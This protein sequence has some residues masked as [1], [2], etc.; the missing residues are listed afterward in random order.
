MNS[1]LIGLAALIMPSLFMGCSESIDG[2]RANSAQRVLKANFNA[3]GSPTVQF[4]VPDMMCEEGCAAAVKGILSKQPGATNVV[5]DFDAK[6]A[7]VA[8]E[9]GTFD[10][11]QALAAL[12]DKGFDHSSVEEPAAGVAP[13][14]AAPR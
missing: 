5:V 6:L 7:T 8:V 13:P 2:P 9:D 14:A 12:V 11:Q 10:A 3:S 1:R 4:A